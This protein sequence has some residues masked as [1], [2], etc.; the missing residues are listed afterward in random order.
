[1]TRE[2]LE[3]Y[4]PY[5]ES[6]IVYLSIEDWRSLYESFDC[7]TRYYLENNWPGNLEIIYHAY[8]RIY[9]IRMDIELST[10]GHYKKI[11]HDK[12]FQNNFDKWLEE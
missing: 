1:M 8:N 2:E 3:D 10:G 6:D 12:K 5:V 9:Y 4:L 11:I 7:N